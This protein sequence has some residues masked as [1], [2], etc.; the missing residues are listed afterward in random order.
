MSAD[1]SLQNI[2]RLRLASV[3]LYQD[4]AQEVIDLFEGV[5]APSF[6]ALT[7]ETLGDAYAALGDYKQ[8]ADAY[9]RALADPSPS[10]TIDAALVQMKLLDLP[11]VV[12]AEA[13][14][15]PEPELSEEPEP[16]EVPM[17]EDGESE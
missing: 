17:A 8:A 11:A 7:N 5:D 13:E 14:P 10:P 16:N 4:R 9:N 3:L 1:E 15:E 6:A 12:V 2:G